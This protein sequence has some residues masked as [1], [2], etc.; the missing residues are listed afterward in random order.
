MI[1]AE[2]V[3]KFMDLKTMIMSR[4][5]I[6]LNKSYAEYK[7]ITAVNVEQITPVEVDHEEVEEGI[8]PEIDEIEDNAVVPA[9]ARTPAGRLSRELKG[10]M[11]FNRDPVC[12]GETAEVAMLNQAFSGKA[13]YSEKALISG[14]DNGSNEPKHFTEMSKHKNQKEWW[15]AMCTKFQNIDS[16]EVWEIKKRKDK[17]LNRKLIGNHWVYKLKN[18]DIYHTCMVA[19]G[20]DQIPGKEFQENHA[21]VV[22]HTTFRITLIL[23]ILLELELEHFDVK[24]AFLYGDLDKRIWMEL[25][26]GYIE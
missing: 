7:G 10:H 9:P 3:Y 2:D 15:D 4:D 23:K 20:Y 8:G 14:F 5:I 24:M 26:E 16:K 11:E 13:F 25:S 21:P 18:N 17:P 19:K 22:N 12:T 1:H 6:W